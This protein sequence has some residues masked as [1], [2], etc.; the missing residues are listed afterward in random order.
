[1]VKR[2]T[3]LDDKYMQESG[4]VFLSSVQALVRLPLIQKRRDADLMGNL[5]CLRR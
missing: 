4:T 2:A 5:C 3:T 1:M